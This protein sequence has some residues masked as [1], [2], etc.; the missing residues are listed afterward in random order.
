[1][2]RFTEAAA[3][4]TIYLLLTAT[5][6]LAQE[7]EAS[8]ADSGIG[9]VVRWLNFAIVMGAIVYFAV[10]KGGPYFRRNADEIAQQIAEGA[11]AREAAE[12]RRR[13]IEEKMAVL[14]KEIE[15]MRA[16]AK[17]DSDAEAKRLRALAREEAE[18]IEQASQAEMAA[19]ERAGRLE[20]KALTARLVVERA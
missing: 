8:P 19:A 5:P 17:R 18:K 16:T 9:W 1:M 7:G 20:L 3:A 2:K 10:K 12:Q 11:R 13:E 14:P 6:A 4:L 15:E